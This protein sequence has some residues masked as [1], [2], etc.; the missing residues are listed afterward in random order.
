MEFNEQIID[1]VYKN[2]EVGSLAVLNFRGDL[3]ANHLP[4]LENEMSV[5]L[6]TVLQVYYGFKA[7]ERMIQSFLLK[8]D[9]ITFQV[10]FFDEIILVIELIEPDSVNALE[11]KLR[12]L[13]H[14]VTLAPPTQ[15][16][17]AS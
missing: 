15:I 9:K 3:Y 11:E 2:T 4:M 7:A 12:K 13:L 8:S 16:L 5:L 1:L 17:K 6:N 10:L 14:D